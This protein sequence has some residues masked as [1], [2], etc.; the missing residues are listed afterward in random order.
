MDQ[1]KRLVLFLLLTGL[2]W[3]GWFGFVQPRFFPL[4]K[5]P[6]AA[7]GELEDDVD[8]LEDGFERLPDEAA[9][10]GDAAAQA[11]PA[12]G[13]AANAQLE[14]PQNPKR[15]V[16]LGSLDPAS[17]YFQQVTL[18]S[19]GAA[20]ESISLNDPRY[21]ELSDRKKPLKVISSPNEEAATFQ[22]A[23]DKLDRQ[24]A[25]FKTSSIETNWKVEKT[26]PDPD[27]PGVSQGVV[28][29]LTAPDGSIQAVKSYT[30]RKVKDST[31]ERARDIEAAG[32]LLDIQ[33]G[34]RNLTDEPQKLVYTLQGPTGTPLENE[35]H[36][37]MYRGLEL[38][39]LEADGDLSHASMAVKEATANA[40]A[41]ADAEKATRAAEA[42]DRRL[43]ALQQKIADLEAQVAATPGDASL[44]TQL[45]KA[46]AEYDDEEVKAGELTDAAQ[47]AN[48]GLERWDTPFK[49]LG[50]EVQYFA[51]LLFPQ[52]KR[53]IAERF[54]SR[55]IAK[56]EP[57][58]VERDKNRDFNDISFKLTSE[59]VTIPAGGEV[60]Q[61]W[62]FFTGPKRKELLEPLGAD[63][64]LDL[65]WFAV[66]SPAMLWILEKLHSTGMPYWLAIISLTVI[67]RGA[68]FP[69]SR[70]QAIG[71]QKM[72]ELQPKLTELK[73]KYGT[74]Q[75]K[76]LK[77]QM[78]LFRKHGYGPL[79][80][81]ASG[82]LPVLL[83]LPIFIGLYQALQT[84][85]DLRMAQFLW[86]DN[87]AAPDQ[88]FRM[89]FSLPYLGADF[90]LLPLITVVLFYIQQKLFMPPATTPEQEAQYKMMNFMMLFMG[91]FFYHVPAGLCVY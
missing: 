32:Y 26:I 29:T 74:D 49:Y 28:F 53:P 66:V 84:S 16:D 91:V 68:M 33:L 65:S 78:E 20:I 46:K 87:L 45:A 10:E 67:V 40:D 41:V 31:P 61:A 39:F 6:P 63:P 64:V 52:D 71:A 73:A 57:V 37:S 88:L 60:T 89:P 69:I 85:V 22:T 5:Q 35:E 76:F 34:F 48:R 8:E 54:D 9:D 11:A 82:C 2:V 47:V 14:A 81:M 77:A 12:V 44:K 30:L 80:P 72:K 56:G 17:G 79:G 83:Q 7:V 70:K 50:V 24:L 23:I 18:T 55:W 58:I 86:I 15:S 59:T 25:A 4:P 36:T 62:Q 19:R 42:A 21:S 75:E 38:G 3:F 51:A 13:E 90:N 43:K 27:Q 1:N